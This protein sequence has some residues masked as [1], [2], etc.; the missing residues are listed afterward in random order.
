MGGLTQALAAAAKDL[1]VEIRTDAEVAAHPRPG[2]RRDR[3]RPGQRRRVHAPAS[4]PAT[5]MPNVT[6]PRLL[7][8]SCCRRSSPRRSAA[9]TT[10]ARR[11]RSTWPC[12][13]CR[14]SPPV[15]GR[16]P[17]RSIA[18]PIH[19]CPDQD[20]IE[21]G[22][23][24][25]QV[26]PA[27]ARPDP[28][29]HHSVGRRSQRGAAGQ[30]PDVDVHSVRRRTSCRR[31]PGTSCADQFADR[32]FDLLNEYAPNFKRS[33]IARQVLTPLDLERTFNLTGGNIFQGA[34]TLQPVVHV[35]RRCSVTPTTARR[36]AACTCA[37]RRRIPAAASWARRGTRPERFWA[38]EFVHFAVDA[39]HSAFR[40][41]ISDWAGA[42]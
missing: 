13:S 1:G 22:L 28:R 5:S 33:V 27:V 16:S 40:S 14:I 6:F 39:E 10:T 7:D 24:R 41:P 11:S 31:A 3:R 9:S 21:R 19:I 12:R 36:S 42:K 38:V 8:P 32:C 23:R 30:A 18:A 26:R 25:R 29:M 37:A 35:P 34:M 4:W 20:Y 17:A 15:P 2:R